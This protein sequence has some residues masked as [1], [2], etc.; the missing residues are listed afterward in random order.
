MELLQNLALGF[1]VAFTPENLLYALL[2]CV[3]GTLVGVLPGLGPVPT[4]AML[5]PITYVLPPVAGLIM[6]AGIYYGTQYGGSTTAILVN[7]PGETSAVVTVLDGHQMARNG[8]AGAALALAAIGSFFAGTVATMLIAAFAPP[9]AEVAFKFGPAEYFSLMVLGLIGAVV[10]ASGSILKAVAM[11]ILGLLLGMVGTDVNSG[12]ARYDFGIPE[13][14]DGID[15]AIVAMGVFGFAEILTNL[16]QKENRVDIT[17]KVGSLYPNKQEMREAAPAIVRGTAL[18]SCLG[19]LPG[20]GSV[21]SAFASYSLEKKLSRNPER[22]GKGHPAGL[23]GP[24]SA[25]NAGAQ[26]SFIPLLTLGIPGNAVMALMVGAMTIHNIQPGPQVMTSHPELFWGL[27]A[28]MWI[29][30]LMLVVLNLPLVGLWVKLLKV[31][32]RILYPAILVFCTIGVYSLNYNVFDVFVTAIFG[33]VGYVWSKLKCEGAPL[34]LGLVLGPMM[35]E[36]FRR[37]L[38]LSRGD[39]LTFVERPL[40]ASLLGAA[41]L[42]VVIVALPSIRKK[43]DETFVEEE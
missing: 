17:D 19:I 14:Q 4:I 42:L 2:G 11:I 21:L 37:A 33:V 41:A 38:L 43:R 26:T 27:I 18:G 9:L 22:F 36:N 25:N 23:A 29:G 7:L 32:Y 28:S 1:S 20:G 10:L 31:P 24:E 15:F 16:E 12:V 6:L 39:F 30:N 13:L 40:S 5:L 35:E 8:R 3:L 34:L